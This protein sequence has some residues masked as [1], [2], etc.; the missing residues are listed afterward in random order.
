MQVKTLHHGP[1]L[2]PS[3]PRQRPHSAVKHLHLPALLH[4]VPKAAAGPAGSA[5]P[6][7]GGDPNSPFHTIAS[8][9]KEHDQA[10]HEPASQ[11]EPE[12]KGLIQRLKHWMRDGKMQREKTASC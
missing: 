6:G 4:P 3:L 7:S 11:G 2:T 9:G 8:V 1:L 10:K 5:S 12:Q